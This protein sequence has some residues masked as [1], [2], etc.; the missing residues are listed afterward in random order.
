MSDS[1]HPRPI[2]L[3][4]RTNSKIY[5]T[6]TSCNYF[7]SPFP[8]SGSICL[9]F[10]KVVSLGKLCPTALTLI[11]IHYPRVVGHRNAGYFLRFFCFVSFACDIYYPITAFPL[12]TAQ[13]YGPYPKSQLTFDGVYTCAPVSSHAHSRSSASVEKLMIW[14]LLM[15]QN[16]Y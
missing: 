15:V 7:F 9:C 6:Q 4:E 2:L 12:S 14:I 10:K 5:F 11:S 8:L 1:Q 13:F 16:Y 3:N